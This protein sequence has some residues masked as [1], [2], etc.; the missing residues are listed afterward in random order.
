MVYYFYEIKKLWINHVVEYYERKICLRI[1]P[2]D[3]IEKQ[4]VDTDIKGHW[5]KTPLHYAC[6]KG[7][8]PIVEYLISKG[9]DIEAED[10]DEATPLHYASEGS[11]A[12]IVKYLISLGANKNAKNI[13]DKTP[14]DVAKNNEI[15]NII[16]NVNAN[17]K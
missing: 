11:K 13:K 16:L 6:W 12:D 1:K 2:R 5:E 8:L 17:P 14:Y 4:N 3:L 10:M 9:A 15:K 7:H